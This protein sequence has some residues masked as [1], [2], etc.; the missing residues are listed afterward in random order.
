[1]SKKKQ[2]KLNAR[3]RHY[4]DGDGFDEGIERVGTATLIELCHSLGLIPESLEKQQ[5][6]RLFRRLW[7]DGDMELRTHILAFFKAENRIYRGENLSQVS[8]ERSEKIAELCAELH[9]SPEEAKLLH[10]AFI[11]VRSSKITPEKMESRLRHLRFE[12]KKRI[13][14]KELGGLFDLDDAFEFNASFLYDCG[15][16]RFKK[17]HTL[18]TRPFEYSFLLEADNSVIIDAITAQKEQLIQTRQSQIDAFIARSVR[19]DHRYLSRDAIV[20]ALKRM[21]PQGTPSAPELT[22]TLLRTIVE[23]DLILESLTQTLHDVLIETRQSLMLPH[24]KSTF[25]YLL[26]LTF[27]RSALLETIWNERDLGLHVRLQ[28]VKKAVVAEFEAQLQSLFLTCK[29]QAKTLQLDDDALYASIYETLVPLMG[30]NLDITPKMHRKV[31]YG[32]GKSIAHL[33]LRRQRSELLARTIRDFKNLFPFARELRRRLVLHIGPTNSGK[34]YAA[35]E[36]LKKAD[37]GSYLAPLRLL[38]LEGYEELREESIKASL[39][40]G[41]EQLIDPEASHISST[42]EML[43]FEVDVDVCVIDEVQMIDDSERGWAW[44][45][46]IIG[47][48]A[49]T[50]IMTGSPNAKEAIVALSEYLGEPLEI[51]EFERKTP[52]HLMRHATP[53]GEIRP[54]TA[55]IAFTRRDVLRLKQQLSRTHRVSVVYGN[56]S[57]EVRR[58]EARRFREGETDVLVATDAIAMGLNLPIETL[59]FSKFEK[60]DGEKSRGLTPSEVHQISGRAGRYGMKSA[61]Y[62]GAL[63]PDVLSYVIKQYHKN[64]HVIAVPFRVMANLDHIRL[65]GSILEERSL[66][67]ILEFFVEHMRFDGPFRATNLETMLEVSAVV[68]RFNLDLSAKF[69]LATAPLSTSSP[70]IMA[71]FERYCALLESQKSVAYLPPKG[72][73]EH[74][75]TM[76]A[77][78]EAE[79]YVKEISLYLWLAYRFSEAFIDAEA[80]KNARAMLNRYIENSLKQSHFVPRCRSCSK[81]LPYNSEFSI[82]QTCFRKLHQNP[83]NSEE[84]M[85][86][87]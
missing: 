86:R 55:V 42:I 76:E 26:S 80:A 74:A 48:P 11:D 66:H 25:A 39:I 75:D 34:T 7:S 18:K 36:R 49:K 13:L 58:E 38:A 68:D 23:R 73:G 16:E 77:L 40:T 33:L 35:F 24:S 3:I 79:D 60:F 63:T 14:E 61:G 20:S 52:L 87:R 27:E 32:F 37:T 65:V 44:A 21:A 10:N 2:S 72:L 41:E 19:S 47:A 85:R 57:P 54:A 17:I 8:Q 5:L 31:L 12:G 6:V 69:T 82:C 22:D 50:I 84:R 64:D 9:V 15:E 46:A 43:N 71:A 51:I 4:F 29:E 45:N 56:L 78:L 83:K 70:Y 67:A 30:Q 81:P 59:L 1:M 28:E 62:V 53:I